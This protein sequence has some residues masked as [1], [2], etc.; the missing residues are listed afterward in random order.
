M[1]LGLK[2][3][4]GYLELDGVR[5]KAAVSNSGKQRSGGTYSAPIMMVMAILLGYGYEVIMG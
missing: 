3:V 2:V 1:V 5:R 4:G